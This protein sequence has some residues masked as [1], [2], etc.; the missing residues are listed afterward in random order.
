[1]RDSLTLDV[2]RDV[3][4]FEVTIRVLGGLLGAHH[5]SGDPLFLQK[6][7]DLG[8]RL[9]PGFDS[10]SG[11]PFSDVNLSS[12]KAHSPKWSPDSST[13]E[14]TTVQLEFRDLT[15]LSGDPKF[16]AKAARVSE[17]VHGLEKLDGLVP[18][19][20]NANT[21]Q[22]RSY[23]T[24]TLGARGDSYYEYLLKQWLQTGKTVDYLKDDYIQAVDGIVKHLAKRTSHSG[25]LFIGEL[26]V[27]GK[28]FKPKM[29]HLTC[30]LPGTLA[31][32]VKYGMPESHLRLAEQLLYT[33]YLTYANQ[34]TFL[35]PEISYF[36]TREGVTS[37]MS[38]KSGDA[39][40]LLRP[41]FV[42]SLFYVYDVTKNAT[43]K[44][45]GWKVAQAIEKHAKVES[46]Y[47]SIGNVRNVDN[48]K[49]RDMM[50]SFFLAETLKYL[51]MLFS[52]VPT[53]DLDKY[54]LNTEAHPIP[55]SS[56]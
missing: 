13:S 1:M 24:I 5:L 49:P 53:I 48:L 42:E 51:W 40:C 23:S 37:D 3:N 7:L 30:Y 56:P 6:A 31:L 54:V 20:I 35:A 55:V 8:E 15:R 41:E 9:L 4:L 12:G 2:N 32:G 29:D 47:T 45:W 39:H 33:C 11:V 10:P 18:I 17:H 34:P 28:D 50:E 25:L 46:G 14:V 44:E 21:G 26:L 19:F 27:G 52:D 36:Y 38:V 22:F 16:E 43:Y